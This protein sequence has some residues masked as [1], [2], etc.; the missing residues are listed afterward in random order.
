[1]ERVVILCLRRRAAARSL[2]SLGMVSCAV[3]RGGGSAATPPRI[4]LTFSP[5]RRR[6]LAS[7]CASCCACVYSLSSVVS[8][9]SVRFLRAWNFGLM[10]TV[11][12]ASHALTLP[13]VLFISPWLRLPCISLLSAQL[14]LKEVALIREAAL[15][16][17]LGLSSVIAS[18]AIALV[19]GPSPKGPASDWP[20]ASTPDLGVGL[21]DPASPLA[22]SAA[23]PSSPT[24]LSL[25]SHSSAPWSRSPFPTGE[26][27]PETVSVPNHESTSPSSSLGVVKS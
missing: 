20:L 2:N 18:L 15:Q 6:R 3:D 27:R 10:G 23:S 13:S 8:V 16:R 1:M 4:L 9:A 25:A 21:S 26:Q 14:S 7:C 17:G 22:S 12:L 11:I 19:F 24:P 5:A